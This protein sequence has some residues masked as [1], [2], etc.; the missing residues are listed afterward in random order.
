[1]CLLFVLF[2]DARGLRCVFLLSAVL[3]YCA[4]CVVFLIVVCCSICVAVWSLWLDVPLLF[5]DCLCLFVGVCGLLFA[6][7]C[8][9]RVVV[10]CCI[11][12]CSLFI[13][14]CVV[15]CWTLCVVCC[16]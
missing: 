14:R 10:G 12:C 1:M 3:C 6:A 5:V 16:S 9:L 4:C 2:V 7:C 13:A 11:V 15:C 8:V